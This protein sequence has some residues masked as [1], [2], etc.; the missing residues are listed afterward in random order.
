MAFLLPDRMSDGG[1]VLSDHRSLTKSIINSTK[2][3]YHE[4]YEQEVAILSQFQDDKLGS[5]NT[6]DL[7]LLSE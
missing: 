2:K 7:D 4:P 5:G 3:T 1:M 6:V